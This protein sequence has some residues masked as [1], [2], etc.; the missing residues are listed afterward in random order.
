VTLENSAA[1]GCYLCCIL[2]QALIYAE[3]PGL[4]LQSS[5][6]PIR[7]SS[8]S[9][10]LTVHVKCKDSSGR[11]IEVSNILWSSCPDLTPTGG[12]AFEAWN[13]YNCM[14]INSY[15]NP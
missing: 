2:Y 15:S 1:G 12:Y 8:D 13:P 5:P 14:K 10:S 9:I 4:Q 7:L 3:I 6:E 11:E